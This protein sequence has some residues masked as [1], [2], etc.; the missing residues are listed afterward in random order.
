MIINDIIINIPH[1]N[2]TILTN[3]TSNIIAGFAQYEYNWERMKIAIGLRLDKYNIK[4]KNKSKNNIS[5]N[6]L[7]PRINFKYDFNSFCQGRISYSQGYR[8]PQIFDEDLHVETS[9][10]RQIIHINSPNLKIETSRSYMMSLDFNKNFSNIYINF[11][12]EGFLPS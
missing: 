9:G 12:I 11:L 8:A 7:N 10:A 6:I 4:D 5:G 1:V 3:Q 2:N